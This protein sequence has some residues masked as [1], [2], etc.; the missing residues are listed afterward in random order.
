M[1]TVKVYKVNNSNYRITIPMEVV[2]ALN[3]QGGD[4]LKFGEVKN[5]EIILRK[6]NRR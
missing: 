3:L 6:C 5:Q 2:R 1:A 4:F